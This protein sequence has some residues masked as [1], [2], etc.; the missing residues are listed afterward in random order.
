MVLRKVKG[1][2]WNQKCFYY[3][4]TVKTPFQFFLECMGKDCIPF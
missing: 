4:I 2:V 3:G 1:S